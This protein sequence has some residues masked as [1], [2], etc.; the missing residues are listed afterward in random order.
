MILKISHNYNKLKLKMMKTYKKKIRMVT[1]FFTMLILMESCVVYKDHSVTLKR[2]SMSKNWVK[3]ETKTSQIFKY[4]QVIFENE[5]YYGINI[6]KGEIVKTELI[7]S[8][9]ASINLEERRKSKSLNTV[10]P[11]AV[12]AVVV[13]ALLIGAASNTNWCCK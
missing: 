6:V 4:E 7:E 5:K 2:A 11:V 8:K 1:F 13:G 12:G 9:I 3:I 10:I